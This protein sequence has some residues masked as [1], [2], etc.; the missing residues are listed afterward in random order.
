MNKIVCSIVVT[1]NRKELLLLNIKSLIEQ[2]YKS[3]ILIVDNASTDGTFDSLKQ[4]FDFNKNDIEY[5]RTDFNMGGAGGF[6]TGLKYAFES[7]KY[8]YFFL[9]DDDGRPVNKETL[10]LL[11]K[12]TDLF[13]TDFIINSIVVEKDLDKLTFGLSGYNSK[14]DIKI[15]YIEGDNN[16]FNGTLISKEIVS[17][18]GYPKKEFF[19]GCDEVEYM[20]RCK[21]NGGNV[22]TVCSSLYF[23]PER[24]FPTENFFGR[25]II[26]SDGKWQSYYRTRNQINYIKEYK[27]KLAAIKFG[28][29]KYIRAIITAKPHKIKT[30][31]IIRRAVI[32]GYK[33]NFSIDDMHITGK[34]KKK[35]KA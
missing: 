32:D 17:K 15:D 23:H 9:M 28:F 11:M 6:Y 20:A 13:G 12:A 34:Y 4:N 19:L 18:I 2:D 35:K 16:P 21:K 1:F 29:K 26:R 8:D 33:G 14:K 10:S 3:H 30:A 22:V 7:G 31:R 24:V 5:I 25:Q 27:G